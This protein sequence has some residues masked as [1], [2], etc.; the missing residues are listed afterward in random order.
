MSRT[1]TSTSKQ[2]DPKTHVARLGRMLFFVALALALPGLASGQEREYEAPRSFALEDKAL[3][4]VDR[5]TLQSIDREQLLAEDLERGKDAES[6]GPARFAV[7][8]AA[9]LDTESSG[10]WLDVSDGRLWRLRIHSPGAVSHNLGFTRFDLPEGAMLWLYDKDGEGV[11]GPYTSKDRNSEGGLWTAVV[12]SDELVIELFVPAGAGQAGLTIGSVNKGYR[13]LSKA[14]GADKHGNCNNNIIC[15]E[16]DPWREQ[17]RSVARYTRSG[18]YFCTGQLMNNTAVNFTPYFLTANHCGITTG[19]DHTLVFYWDYEAATCGQH[20]GGSLATNQGGATLLASYT[21]SDFALVL[22]DAAPVAADPFFSGWDRTG[23]AA[24]STVAIHH[25]Q[26]DVKSISFNIDAVTSTDYLSNAVDPTEDHWRVDDWEDGTTE[27]GSSGGC[28]WDANNGLCVGQLQGGY[29]SCASITSDWYGKLSVSWTGGGTN[30]TRLSNWLDPVPTGQLTLNGDPHITT[31]DGVHYDFQGAGEYVVLREGSGIEVQARQ[32]PIATTFN[33]G[34]DGYHGLATCVSL[35]SA[36]AARVGDRRVTYQPN[37][38]GVPDPSGLQ[39]RVD[40]V[41]RTL[42]SDGIDLGNGGSIS[43]TSAPGGI[44]IAF[45]TKYLLRVTPG[46]WSSQSKWYLNIGVVPAP[47]RGAASAGASPSDGSGGLGA[48]LAPGSWL[49]PLPDGSSMGPMPGSLH[50]RYVA[51]YDTFGEAWR[52]TDASSLFDYASGT[53]TDDF[54]LKSWPGESPPCVLPQ[55]VKPVKPVDAEV[56]QEACAEVEQDQTRADCIFDVRVTGE[57]GFAQTYV[58]TERVERG[59][60]VTRPEDEFAFSIHLGYPI[61][62]GNFE[63]AGFDGEFAA[64]LDLEWRY[65]PQRSLEVVLGRYA[66]EFGPFG[67]DIDGLTAYYK[68]YT[69][70]VGSPR[71][72]WQ[73]GAGFYDVQPGQSTQGVSGGAGWQAPIGS[74]LEFE[75]AGM[76]FHLFSTGGQ[77]DIDFAV[78]QVGLKLTF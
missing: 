16:G 17:I 66:F 45:P 47:G 10:S 78:A 60:P 4:Q 67:V 23:V 37:L 14:G 2:L 40:G 19:N 28:L 39:L 52:V 58:A 33:P 12:E 9:T 5:K 57:T 25:P 32:A 8:E 56:A 49:P 64:A 22:L 62:L 77:G 30:A 54:T 74:N 21:P 48:R 20:G 50:D 69:A 46:W 51:L 3:E 76:L 63:N 70:P 27:G 59:D 29:A 38:S 18:V 75:A 68:A 6:P 43:Q 61:P 35:N 7:S 71:V 24:L 72:F 41:L 44:E 65:A 34:P 26:G 31:L 55:Q 73:L 42:S 15:P 13:G 53:S 11:L 36:M 1:R